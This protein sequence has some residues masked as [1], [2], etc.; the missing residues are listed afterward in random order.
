M[1]TR[2]ETDRVPAAEQLAA[3]AR[4]H[5]LLDGHGIEYW[6]FGGWAV[7]F[8]AG[9]VTRPHHDIDLAV[10]QHD[11]PT[12]DAALTTN[13]W[14][15]AVVDDDAIGGAFRRAGVLLEL[16][17]VVADEQGRVFLPFADGPAM[18]SAEPFGDERRELG[19][20][21]CRVI[22]LS[23]LASDK[24]NA[25]EDPADGAKDRLDR[26]VLRRLVR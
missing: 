11:R 8:W 7:D 25:R 13:G 4:I 22:S 6:L 1:T 20:V 10:W 5:E 14:M 17:F 26:D 9:R 19:G 21:R 15:P 16:T 3:L 18:W 2:R 23:T 12:V 24:S